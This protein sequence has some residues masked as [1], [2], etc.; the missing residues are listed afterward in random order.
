MPVLAP[1]TF[2]QDAA[3]AAAKA[4]DWIDLAAA[5]AMG[6]AALVAVSGREER[7]RLPAKERRAIPEQPVRFRLALILG[8]VL[9]ESLVL[10]VLVV[11]RIK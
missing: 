3:S 9:I 5:I 10:Y 2:A 8:L 4:T 7:P 11:V 1:V 6:I